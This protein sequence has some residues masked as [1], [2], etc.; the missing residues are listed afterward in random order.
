MSKENLSG[1]H[2]G[3]NGLPEGPLEAPYGVPEGPMEAPMECQKTFMGP[4][5]APGPIFIPIHIPIPS[6]LECSALARLAR[7]PCLASARSALS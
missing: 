2:G 5:E 6:L 4:M 3:S 7:L 1:T